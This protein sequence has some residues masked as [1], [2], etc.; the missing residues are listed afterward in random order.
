M[1]ISHRVGDKNCFYKIE[2]EKNGG[3]RVVF[4]TGKAIMKVLLAALSLAA[5]VGCGQSPAAAG[6]DVSVDEALRLWQNKEAILIDVRTPDEY[7]DG[8]IPGVANIPLAELEKRLGEVPKDKK[9]VIICRTGNRSAQGTKLLRGKGF[10]NVVNST[11]GMS[12]WKGPV[13]K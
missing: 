9:V 10:D 5:V 6:V 13:E 12:T 11:G 7:R 4:N 2:Q 8:H 3:G 1:W